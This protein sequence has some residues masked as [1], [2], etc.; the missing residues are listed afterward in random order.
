VK[1]AFAL[2]A[3]GNPHL[4]ERLV[5]LLVS[6]GHMVVLHYDL[7]SPKVHY[8]S[9]RRAFEQ[10]ALV[11]FAC[12]VRVG[13]AEWSIV[14]AT[15][16]CLEE[17]E[18]SGWDP[19]YVY[20]LSGMDYPIRSSD[21]LVKFL[22]RNNGKEYIE[23]V[24]ADTV[25]WAKTG[26]QQERYQY[27]FYF[28]WREQPRLCEFFLA[29][30]KRL[31]LK[32]KFVR[33]MT[34][35]IGSQWWVLTWSTLRKVMRLARERDIERFFRTVLVPDE[36]FFHTMVR[37]LVPASRIVN[38]TLTLYQ[39][40][41]YG[42][43]VVYYADHVDYL[44]RQPFF[45]ARK[46]SPHQIALRDALDAYWRGERRPPPR[47]DAQI[48][49]RSEGYESWRLTYRDGVPGQPLAGRVPRRRYGDLER[50]TIPYFA[51][52]G[53]SSAELHLLYKAL[54][55]NPDI[56]CHGQLFHRSCIEFANGRRSFAG[57]DADAIKLRGLAPGNFLADVVRAAKH[58]LTGFLLRAEQGW[59][60]PA[61]MFEQPNARV[62]V[63]RG[64]PLIA[65]SEYILKI[66]PMLDE[67]FDEAAFEAIPRRMLRYR[68]RQFS[69]E[70]QKF[71]NWLNGQSAHA[72]AIKPKGWLVEFD[73]ANRWMSNLPAGKAAPRSTVSSLMH[74]ELM[75]W[76]N[77]PRHS[78]TYAAAEP[79]FD[80]ELSFIREITAELRRLDSL[81]RLVSDRLAIASGG[82]RRSF[83]AQSGSRRKL[84][85]YSTPRERLAIVAG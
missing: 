75:R 66:E 65:F 17:I 69:R 57:Y 71:A 39:F 73:L 30:Q 38:R 32:R 20:Y 5:R 41:D 83:D 59:H 50:L 35:Y 29:L 56:L 37:H 80:E 49:V 77:A 23:S 19:D 44:T 12:R 61:V 26:P 36:L 67:P 70:F 72:A 74:L 13:W 27:R 82:G 52:I 68:F 62:L 55:R 21:Q 2:L 42:M 53:A 63:I 84:V 9:L 4:V 24:P 58:Q 78:E 15:L 54:S 22:Q 31:G 79:R 51:V 40:S 3:H 76:R 47:D 45:M 64:D 7:K 10:C 60:L 18:I 33:G 14:E 85:A 81:R 34:P 8:D 43:P 11:R 16:K 28:N 48:G 6:A 46:L 1:I 25:P